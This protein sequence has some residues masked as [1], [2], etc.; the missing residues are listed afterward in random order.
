[1]G[2]SSLELKTSSGLGDEELNSVKAL[3]QQG[4]LGL[5]EDNEPGGVDAA[6]TGQNHA[7]AGL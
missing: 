2:P 6:F 1:M 5:G 4:L 7:T 3:G